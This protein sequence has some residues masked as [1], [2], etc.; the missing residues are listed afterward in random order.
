[1]VAGIIVEFAEHGSRVAPLVNN[2]IARHLLGDD[3]QEGAYQVELP[4]DSAPAS[5]PIIPVPRERPN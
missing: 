1:M 2:V 5:V 3:Y 4:A